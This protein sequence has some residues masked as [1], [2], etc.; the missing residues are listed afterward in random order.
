MGERNLLKPMLGHVPSMPVRD[1]F[2]DNPRALRG[3]ARQTRTRPQQ[4]RGS[5]LVKEEEGACNV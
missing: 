2:A 3:F 1:P 5:V 4:A